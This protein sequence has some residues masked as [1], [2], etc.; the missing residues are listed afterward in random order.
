MGG[1]APPCPLALQ[2][3]PGP[4]QFSPPEQ[5][6]PQQRQ[7]QD[8]ALP[9]PVSSPAQCLACTPPPGSQA[10][11]GAQGASAP[12]SLRSFQSRLSAVFPR[13]NSHLFQH[14]DFIKLGI[15]KACFV[16]ESELFGA[17]RQPRPP[18]L[19]NPPSLGFPWHSTESYST[20]Q[21]RPPHRADWTQWTREPLPGPHTQILLMLG[22]PS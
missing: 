7:G 5:L 12:I 21:V 18:P 2:G 11:R 4:P 22:S 15:L 16:F 9:K 8:R 14:S 13:E 3:S 19:S 1:Q 17:C 10:V 20:W 6:H